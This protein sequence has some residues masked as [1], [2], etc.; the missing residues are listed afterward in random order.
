MNHFL[1][2]V[3]LLAMAVCGLA[4]ADTPSAPEPGTGIQGVISMSPTHG[5]PIRAD[6]PSS[7]PLANTNFVV[8]KG[9]EV[10]AS[11]TTDEQGR[12]RVSLPA[13]RYSVTKKDRQTRIGHY[14]PFEVDVV[15]GQIKE[16]AWTCDTGMR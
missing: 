7:K 15:A 9:E 2:I 16:V 4:M 1:P 6:V 10:V 11:F 13:G 12:F 14:G 3:S 8:M 5:G